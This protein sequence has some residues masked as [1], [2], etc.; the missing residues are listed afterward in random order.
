[1]PT[2]L[3]EDIETFKKTNKKT[4]YRL[5]KIVKHLERVAS[6]LDRYNTQ[7]AGDI[8]RGMVRI[9]NEYVPL[10]TAVHLIFIDHFPMSY[11]HNINSILRSYDDTYPVLSKWLLVRSFMETIYDRAR[12][13]LC[14]FEAV[15]PNQTPKIERYRMLTVLDFKLSMA[16]H[17]GDER[18]RD[19]YLGMRAYVAAQMVTRERDMLLFP[20]TIKDISA[21]INRGKRVQ[22]FS[23]LS[24]TFRIQKPPEYRLIYENTSR[25]NHGNPLQ[26]LVSENLSHQ[27]RERFLL[28]GMF[29]KSSVD[30]LRL[31][32]ED[33]EL[34]VPLKKENI[35]LSDQLEKFFEEVLKPVWH[36]AS[37]IEL[38]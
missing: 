1:M 13:S 26:M 22:L 10:E 28:H 35:E 31:I 37:S 11:I 5:K 17:L 3:Q 36:H 14:D 6:E 38:S 34:S 7:R 16:T 2:L 20:E 9:N 32:Q 8:G 29:I 25:L 19:E 24:K 4:S 18:W 23:D 33:V 21:D 27:W 12:V 30:L 15:A